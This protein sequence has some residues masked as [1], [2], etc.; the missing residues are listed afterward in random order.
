[1][2]LEFG[3]FRYAQHNV[4]L[5]TKEFSNGTAW[6]N[7]GGVCVIKKEQ[8]ENKSSEKLNPAVLLECSSQQLVTRILMKKGAT[9]LLVHRD[10]NSTLVE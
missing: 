1:M 5:A 8:Y 7:N 9:Q 6:A 4:L 3:C 2:A 10:R